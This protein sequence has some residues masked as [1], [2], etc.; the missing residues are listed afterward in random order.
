MSSRTPIKRNRLYWD[1]WSDEYQDL[2]GQILL[3]TALAWGVWRIPESELHILGETVGK[4]ILEYGCGAAQWSIG[5]KQ[6]GANV[7]GLDL[8]TRQLDYA[9]QNLKNTEVTL[10]LVQA[11]GEHL[12]FA[13]ETFDIIFCDHG[14]MSF[15]HP[16]Y[17]LGEVARVLRPDGLFA[18]CMSTPFH[19]VC[20]DNEAD[21]VI[22][23][24]YNCYFGMECYEDGQST[25]Y[26]IGYGEWIRLFRKYQFFIEDLIE[27]RAPQNG[28]T[29]YIH[30]VSYEWARNWPAEHIWKIRKGKE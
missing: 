28:K 3:D 12:P 20:W 19:E 1:Q 30:F 13:N 18:F 26:Q 22:D 24:L 23:R 10:P 25:S 17:T 7:T 6:Q 9:I 4:D 2:H 8:S 14:V 16:D 15:A 5:L 27:L 29:S 21:K 11:D